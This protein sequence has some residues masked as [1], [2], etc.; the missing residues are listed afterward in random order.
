MA[1]WLAVGRAHVASFASGFMSKLLD[2]ECMPTA[3]PLWPILLR[4]RKSA[5]LRY[6]K[7]YTPLHR[8]WLWSWR[9]AKSLWT[10]MRSRIYPQTPLQS[11]G[12][13]TMWRFNNWP[14]N[15]P[16]LY[17]SSRIMD[18]VNTIMP[19]YGTSH[20]AHSHRLLR[21]LVLLDKIIF[22]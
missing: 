9:G 22:Q 2:G 13:S 4:P 10:V 11:L 3:W 18:F 15:Q 16:I 19:S 5:W 17:P 6:W 14:M 21:M 12:C 7:K 20:H 8:G 1:Y